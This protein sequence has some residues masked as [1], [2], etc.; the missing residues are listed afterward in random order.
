LV[1]VNGVASAPQLAQ[2]IAS[3]PMPSTRVCGHSAP[4]PGH[5]G[6][7]YGSA[8][9]RPSIG[10]SLPEAVAIDV[11]AMS[12]IRIA[13]PSPT[14]APATATGCATSCPPRIAGVI[15]GPQQPGAVFTTM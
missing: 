10:W 12:R 9:K 14:S 1:N 2:R 11:T 13:I 8:L 5:T 15:I 6:A 7:Q 3:G 4:Q